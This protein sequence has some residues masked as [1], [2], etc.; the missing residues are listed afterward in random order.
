MNA[1]NFNGKV[2]LITGSSRGIGKATALA[3]AR[4]GAKIVI[5]YATSQKEAEKTLKQVKALGVDAIAIQCNVSSPEQVK[6]MVQ[7]TVETFGRI[8]VLVNNA[9]V[10]T[11]GKS[12]LAELT[13]ED[14]E[15]VLHTNL[16]GVFLCTQAVATVM[17]KQKQ[18]KIVNIASIR[19]LEHCGRVS[20][21]AASKAGVINFTKTV[22]KELAPEI[23]V[24]CVAPGWVETEMNKAISPEFRKSET[25]KTYL[26]RFAKPEEI[27]SAIMFLA[28]DE[29]S[30]I[31]GNV[32]VVD[33]GYS[34]K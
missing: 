15:K 34:L 5:N 11:E 28:S 16:I 3:F 30:Y 10:I 6:Q 31:T 23:N 33:G 26:K 20:D 12:S 32:L 22:A 1:I 2:V 25:E 7:K 9:G 21:Y 18:G 4:Q 24:N 13:F 8:D 14:W 29:A 17:K 27:A 19:G